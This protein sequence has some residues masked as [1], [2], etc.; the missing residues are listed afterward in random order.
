VRIL[1]IDKENR[2]IS[3]GLKQ[4]QDDPWPSLELK[5]AI[6]TET[7]GTI[8]RLLDRG[9]IVELEGDVE[10]FIPANMLGKRDINKPAEAFSES[11]RIPLRVIEFDSKNRKIIL[12]VDAYY[13]VREKEEL[14]KFIA[15]Y[16]T[17]TLKIK[18]VVSEDLSKIQNGDAKQ[19][20]E[21]EPEEEYSP[22]QVSTEPDQEDDSETD[23]D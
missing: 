21:K 4:V 20:P 9:V 17:R 1:S 14:E 8:T 10:G 16:P 19:E 7:L 15:K 12:S 23:K 2:R 18:D 3:L 6:N 13:A 22:A 11:D 5:Y